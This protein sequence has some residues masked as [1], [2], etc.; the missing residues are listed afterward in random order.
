MLTNAT[1]R[2]TRSMADDDRLLTVEE[3]A[4]RLRLSEEVVRRKL[5]SG[6]LRGVRL[7]ERRAGWRITEGDLRRFLEARRTAQHLP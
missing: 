6:E 5:R 4:Q 1:Y 2:Y 7:G 3:V